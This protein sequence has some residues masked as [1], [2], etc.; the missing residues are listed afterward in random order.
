D[1]TFYQSSYAEDGLGGESSTFS[2]V[3]NSGRW[4]PY[5][6]SALLF[7]GLAGHFLAMLAA[8]LKN[9]RAAKVRP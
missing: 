2:V 7:L 8:A 9:P 4:L 3:R 5:I 6:A 1:Y